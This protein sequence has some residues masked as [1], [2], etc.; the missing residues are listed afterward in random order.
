M[1]SP[2]SKKATNE[3]QLLSKI[4]KAGADIL[5]GPICS[6][7]NMSV[8][9]KNFPDRLEQAQVSPILKRTTHL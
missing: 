1:K 2:N 3:D 7:Y 6:I 8:N 5:P 4:I 9:S